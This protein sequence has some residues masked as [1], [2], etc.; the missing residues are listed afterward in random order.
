MALAPQPTTV[1]QDSVDLIALGKSWTP[2]KH[3]ETSPEV[4]E[5]IAK[6][7]WWATRSLLYIIV[8]FIIVAFVWA[9]VSKVDMV[10]E[11]RG[12]LIPGGLR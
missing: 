9:S 12:T 11:G 7:P 3:N 10:A 1:P 5:V 2:P 6:M 8:T 4:L